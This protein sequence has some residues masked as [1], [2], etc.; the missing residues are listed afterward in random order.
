MTADDSK[1]GKPPQRRP[2][3]E[4]EQGAFLSRWARRKNAAAAGAPEPELDEIAA[5]AAEAEARERAEQQRLEAERAERLAAN[6]AA[7]EAVDLENADE[8]TDFKLFMKEGVPTT[9][10]QVAL[11]KLWTVHPIFRTLDGLNDYDQDFNVTHTI[12]TKFESAW[13]VGKG[14]KKKTEEEVRE[15]VEAGKARA[16]SDREEADARAEEAGRRAEEAKQADAEE[17]GTEEAGIEEAEALA[18]ENDQPDDMVSDP[19][20]IEDDAPP[21]VPLRRRFALEDWE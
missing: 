3:S 9:L 6:R 14:Y 18:A 7:A 5:R 20:L 16:A 4:P 19:D 12:L 11:R 13:K 2:E 1:D 10:R 17:A 15:M 21:R 8:T